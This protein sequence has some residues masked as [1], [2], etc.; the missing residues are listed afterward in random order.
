MSRSLRALVWGY[1]IVAA[2]VVFAAAL[3]LPERGT[4]GLRVS[5]DRIMAVTPGGPAAQAGLVA[6]EPFTG[7]PPA[8]PGAR[9]VVLD[10]NGDER[11]LIAAPADPAEGARTA[12]LL[13]L[14]AAFAL[15]GG[16]ALAARGDRLVL[17][18]ALFAFSGALAMAPPLTSPP[19]LAGAPGAPLLAMLRGLAGLLLA[20]ALVDFFARFPES[21]PGRLARTLV[22]AGYVAAVVLFLL[23]VGTDLS[24]RLP[25]EA[26]G[27]AATL[28]AGGGYDALAA[29]FLC[30]AIVTALAMFV[31]RYAR[32]S[33]RHRPRLT[34]LVW[35]VTLGLAP[36]ALLML[37]KNVA[38][39]RSWPG[40]AFAPLFLLLV[41]AGFGYATIVHRVFDGGAF[42]RR[43]VR[44]AQRAPA[45]MDGLS[46]LPGRTTAFAPLA[47]VLDDAAAELTQALGL[48]HCAVFAV[49][50]AGSGGHLLSMHGQAATSHSGSRR[51]LPA[52]GAG[53]IARLTQAHM[54]LAPIEL[55]AG[56]N[57]GGGDGD[58]AMAPLVDAGTSLL[59]PLFA[60]ER[61]HAVLALGPRLS[62][63][64]F[65]DNEREQV[66]AYARQASALMEN[67]VLHDRLV[68]RAGL[69]RD[70]ELARRIQARLLPQSVPVFPTVDI[71]AETVPAGAIGGDSY[72][73]LPLGPRTLGIAVA[74]VCGKGLPASL[75]L[76]GVQAGLRSRAGADEAPGVALRHINEELVQVSQPEKFVCLAYARLDARKRT[77]RW[78]NAGLN[79]PIV[80]HPDGSW[81]EVEHGGLILGVSPGQAYEELEWTFERGSLIAFHTDGLTDARRGDTE[82]G[83]ERLGQVLARN[84]GARAR[85]IA[86][87]TLAAAAEWHRD[88][89]A[90]D[91][92]IVILK[93]L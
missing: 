34:A 63:P 42:L 8:V 80:V 61:C 67:A 72:D 78:A 65:D 12:C 45:G 6:G 77:L 3:D 18:F 48:E 25:A 82:F 50:H 85:A 59:V 27:P 79:P 64:W 9:H 32:A 49:A 53:T 52:L 62:G 81:E 4:W 92:T 28:L 10:T 35:S 86:E 69:E 70:V 30:G 75:L 39:A 5:G 14:A 89:P 38:P 36:I 41:P 15:V 54:P 22:A 91:R 1:G 13:L 71:A 26:R 31:T 20:A 76:A 29:L 46:V 11:T 90:D 58:G 93:F 43:A 84:R 24:S 60:E 87:R 55:A 56:E 37:A 33:A 21:R 88:G 2:L 16:A 47:Q 17:A 23:A 74:D 44:G 51:A 73:F 57:D 66:A 40:E 19:W 7:A 83:P 68:E